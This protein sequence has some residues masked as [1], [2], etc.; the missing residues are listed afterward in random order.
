M[1]RY[2]IEPVIDVVRSLILG[3]IGSVSAMIKKVFARR[4]EYA[5]LSLVSTQRIEL[6]EHF[7]IRLSTLSGTSVME[8]TP[9][10]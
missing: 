1:R 9:L 3:N 2:R 8:H 5:F 10:K 7:C 6:E 4:L